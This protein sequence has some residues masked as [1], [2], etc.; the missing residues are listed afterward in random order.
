MTRV[1]VLGT[2]GTIARAADGY[3]PVHEVLE[4]VRRQAPAVLSAEVVVEPV[5]VLSAAAETFAPPEW[6]AINRAIQ[7]RLRRSPAIDGI[8]VTHGSYTVEETAYFLHLC[9]AT[10]LPIVLTCAQ[11]LPGVPGADGIANLVDAIRVAADPDSRGRGALVV[12]HEE[13]HSARDVVK[14]SQ[15]PGGFESRGSGPLGSI[16]SDLVTY[17]RAPERRHTSR[18]AVTIA[19]PPELPRV[20]VVMTYAGADGAPIRA[21]VAAG[22]AG[23]VVN[24]FAYAGKPHPMQQDALREALAAGVPVVL[25]SRGGGGRVPR[26]SRSEFISGDNL[27]AQKARILLQLGLLQTTDHARLQTLFDTH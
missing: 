16:E 9:V 23:L 22:A 18:S 2:G 4:L 6:L 26:R 15:R 12:V 27:A 1:L 10:D 25:V 14:T 24:G 19:D 17:Y 20:D 3:L 5:D 8:V 11:R 13:I 21:C 7:E